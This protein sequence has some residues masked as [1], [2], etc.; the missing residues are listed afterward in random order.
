MKRQIRS[1]VSFSRTEKKGIAALCGF[2]VLL[3]VIRFSMHLW[4]HP[5]EDAA[6][7]QKLRQAWDEFQSVAGTDGMPEESTRKQA[8]SDSVDINTAD[9]Q[10]LILFNGIGPATAHKILIRR[11]KTGPFTDISQI[12]EIGSFSA[13]QMAVLKAHLRVPANGKAGH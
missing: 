7:E 1:F 3:I 4:V 9:S 5:A 12:R 13:E 2:I 11:Q 6:Q 8:L 10:T